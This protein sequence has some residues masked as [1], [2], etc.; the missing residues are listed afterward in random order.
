MSSENRNNSEAQC[1]DIQL[2]KS[3]VS[4]SHTFD[5]ILGVLD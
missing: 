1:L 5:N 2:F 3:I 4:K